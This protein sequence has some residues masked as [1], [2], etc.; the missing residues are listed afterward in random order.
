[1]ASALAA[2]KVERRSVA[3]AVFSNRHLE[4]TQV[5]QLSSVPEKADATTAG[6][7]NWILV[8]FDVATTAL[9]QA[10]NGSEL[11]RVQLSEVVLATLRDA[12]VPVWEAPKRELFEAYGAPPLKTRKELREVVKS[13]WPILNGRNG[14]GGILDAVALGL[15]F[16]TERLFHQ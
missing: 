16:Q 4:Y 14:D 7:V 11:R 10:R 2:I 3:V 15:Y 12:G 9:D 6:F 1:M 8:T 5:R 13:I